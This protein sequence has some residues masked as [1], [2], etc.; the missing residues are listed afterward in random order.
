MTML[1]AFVGEEDD[2]KAYLDCV[3]P[4][5]EQYTQCIADDPSCQPGWADDCRTTRDN[6]IGACP[7]L[8]QITLSSFNACHL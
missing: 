4:V 5:L 7:A 1:D 3:A 6:V 8:A 2:A